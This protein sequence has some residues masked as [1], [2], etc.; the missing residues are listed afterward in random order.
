MFSN[1]TGLECIA[2]AELITA[3]GAIDEQ[4][5]MGRARGRWHS[6]PSAWQAMHGLSGQLALGQA[7][8][9]ASANPFYQLAAVVPD[10]ATEQESMADSAN[11]R[12]LAR[13]RIDL[14]PS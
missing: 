10:L 12:R 3:E 4:T 14:P 11:T 9:A 7:E 1:S 6:Y 8:M 13:R 2:E 5:L